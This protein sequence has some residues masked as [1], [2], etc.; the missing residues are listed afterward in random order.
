[1]FMRNV[2]SRKKKVVKK[3][4]DVFECISCGKTMIVTST[5]EHKTEW[6][7]ASYDVWEC[8]PCLK[9][10]HIIKDFKPLNMPKKQQTS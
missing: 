7:L 3:R 10:E 2:S 9:K 5:Y 1:M 4:R 8:K 6:G